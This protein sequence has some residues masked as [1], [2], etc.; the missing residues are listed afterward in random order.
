M[1]AIWLWTLLVVPTCGL[2]VAIDRFGQAPAD[3]KLNENII[4]NIDKTPVPVPKKVIQKARA[5]LPSGVGNV[6][7]LVHY[8]QLNQK[9]KMN[10]HLVFGDKEIEYWSGTNLDRQTLQL[11]FAARRI[12]LDAADKQNVA[13]RDQ[14]MLSA[15]ARQVIPDLQGATVRPTPQA[16]PT[17]S[18]QTD[19][20]LNVACLI[21]GCPVGVTSQDLIKKAWDALN[22]NTSGMD[23]KN[24][25]KALSCTKV[26]IA[27]FAGDADEQQATRLQANECKKTPA[28]E[29]KERDAYF[30]SYWALSDVAAAWFIRGQVLEQ[31]KNCKEAKEAYETIV[32]KYNC[33][34][35]WDP[36]GW[37]WNAA[38]GADQALKN[39][40]SEG[41]R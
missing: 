17:A 39:L 25:E 19:Q 5:P 22:A 16:R 26:T 7:S 40:E 20:N 12:V 1:K 15:A 3:N 41:C 14:D 35:I 11:E 9:P 31:Q 37:F 23:P 18:Q 30:G 36:R 21:C 10:P 24:F 33:A 34:F 32:A 6:K 2:A 8:Y 38:K 29:E 28:K 13:I 4:I 27:R